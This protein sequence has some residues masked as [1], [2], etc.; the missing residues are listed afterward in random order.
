MAISQEN[1]DMTL[2]FH[3]SM[4]SFSNLKREKEQEG[5]LW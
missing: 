1:Y 3:I 2:T 5:K 4:S